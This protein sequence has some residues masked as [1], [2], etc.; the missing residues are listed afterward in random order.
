MQYLARPGPAP[1][2]YQELREHLRAVARR[3]SEAGRP[4]G[5][6]R[7]AWWAGMLHDLG[8]YSD[9]FQRRLR[10]PPG[11]QERA[12]HA[13]H[14]AWVAR[15]REWIEVAL[16]VQ[17]HHSGLHTLQ[18]LR[19]LQTRAVRAAVDSGTVAER[20]EEAWGRAQAELPELS[21]EPPPP[22]P[23][24]G[25]LEAE[26]RV[27]FL[28][29]CLADAD[30]LDA[31]AFGSPETAVQ[32]TAVGR[33]FEPESL[34]ARLLQHI[35]GL[36]RPASPEVTSARR[37]LLEACL[38]AGHLPQ[39]LFSLTAPTGSGKTLASIAFAL[40]HAA[41]HGLRRVIVVLPYLSIIE[42]NAEVYAEVFGAATVLEHHSGTPEEERRAR[43]GE[44]PSAAGDEDD[45]SWP[46]TRRRLLAENWD[47]PIV[48]TTS[49]QFLESLFSH[50]PSRLRK[51]HNI[52]RS[53]VIFD[54]VQT[55][56]VEL[57]DPT[58]RMLEQLAAGYGTTF[59]FST[60]TQ[61]AFEADPADSRA[62]RLATGSVREIV[63]SPEAMAR[64]LVRVHY[65]WRTNP[66]E[67]LSWREAA[68]Q[69]AGRGQALAVVNVRD[70]ARD[71]FRELC[72]DGDDEGIFHLS[73]RMCPQHRLDTIDE[74]KVRLARGERC[75]VAATQLVEAGVD[76][77]F[78]LVLRALGP[79]DSI[80]Q[81]AGRCNRSG[82]MPKPGRVV[83]FAPE[84]GRA[85]PGVYGIAIGNTRT[86]IGARTV[87]GVEPDMDDPALFREYFARL[88][89][90]AETDARGIAG[91]RERLDFPSVAESYRVIEDGTLT[92]Y[93]EYGVN[94]EIVGRL[95]ASGAPPLQRE[96]RRPLQRLSVGLWRTELK[97]ALATGAVADVGRAESP[98]YV[99][100]EARYDVRLGVP[101]DGLEVTDLIV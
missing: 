41:V 22:S 39:G 69:M 85:P 58:L 26:L 6:E 30:R 32:R 97:N 16:A 38:K 15:Q 54:E 10:A 71:L 93:V 35:A 101:V 79:L 74:I 37:D 100:P 34:L 80:A 57:L 19:D 72:A 7:E 84:D 88:Y 56:P 81:A 40:R 28:L 65:E 43:R 90:S 86:M 68:E 75:L 8:K 45:P 96:E 73:T 25:R 47:A 21:G 17:G 29:S 5:L 98:I 59:V 36:D 83:V 94:K 50:H 77:D 91:M 23:E 60:A 24:P 67:E 48:V 11:R 49:V 51:V 14:G 52:A 27:R 87:R 89:N 53:V 82:T 62:R 12:E 31:E 92:V 1:G 95:R 3:A 13:A 46:A 2:T 66:G 20:A 70:H 76:L 42:Q 9:A 33:S 4:L 64:R 78:P 63:P 61:P 55:L 44:A 99:C 18:D